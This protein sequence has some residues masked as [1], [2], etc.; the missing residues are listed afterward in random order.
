MGQF[1]RNA[2]LQYHQQAITHALSPHQSQKNMPSQLVFPDDTMAIGSPA[3]N[4][5]LLLPTDSD[6]AHETEEDRQRRLL[7]N[8]PIVVY[9]SLSE[10]RLLRPHIN[11]RLLAW[12]CVSALQ[13]VCIVVVLAGGAGNQF[14]DAD[15]STPSAWQVGLYGAQLLLHSFAMVSM[16]FSS[17][18][19]LTVYTVLVTLV[20]VL[21]AAWA[22]RS[23]VDVLVCS[24]CVPAIWLGNSIRDLMMPHCFTIRS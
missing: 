3:A 10:G 22:V 18:D 21:M 4:A 5:R 24:L 19:L 7:Q 13:A 8:E 2:L 20:C 15:E 16:Y 12:A 17:T 1:D 14:Y 23:F 11:R 9:T 6:G